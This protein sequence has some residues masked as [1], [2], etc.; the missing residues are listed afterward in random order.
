MTLWS[1][2]CRLTGMTRIARGSELFNPE[3][4]GQWPRDR[5]REVDIVVG[6]LFLM[7][8][9][10]WDALGGFDPAFTMYGEEADLCLRA[11]ARGMRPLFTPE[12]EIIHYGGASETVQADKMVR[13]MRAKTELI[14]RHAPAATRALERRLFALWPKSRQMAS[15][16]LARM[17]RGAHHAD[18]ARVWAEIW[19]RR[20]E[21]RDGF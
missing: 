21:W 4:Y 19:A 15:A 14:K 13:I 16:A 1:H 2:L 8:R 11:K 10:D 3:T 9:A 12:A 17:G 20:A 7:R 6:C 18:A 5:V